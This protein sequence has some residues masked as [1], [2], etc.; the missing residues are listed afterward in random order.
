[1]TPNILLIITDQQRAD[2]IGPDTAGPDRTPAL[3][4]L[5][6]HAVT[7]SNAFTT[8]PLCGPARA[9][10][11]S[12]RYPHQA[13]GRPADDPLGVRDPGE[14]DAEDMMLNDSS[15]LEPPH[16]T[17]RLRGAGYYTGYAGKWHLGNDVIADWFPDHFGEDN[18]QYVRWLG[19]NGK[20]DGWPLHD[21]DVRSFRPP[22]MSIPRPKVN[23]I[24]PDDSNDAWIADHCVKRIEERPTDR[25]FFV[26]CGFNGPHP[27]FKIPEPY[28]S[29]F[30]PS[31]VPEPANF[32]PRPG[33]PSSRSESYYRRL[34]S[35]HGHDWSDWQKS[36][37]VYWGFVR[38]I[39]DQVGKLVDCLRREGV[40]EETVVVFCSDHGEMLG[41]HGLWHKMQ[42][43]EEAIRVPLVIAAPWIDGARR[44]D[45]LVSLIDL[46]PTILSLAGCDAPESWEETDLSGAVSAIDWMPSRSTVFVEQK[47]LGPFHGE[48]SWRLARGK[49]YK[50]VWNDGDTDELYDLEMDP[51]E[52]NNIAGR[53]DHAARL[54]E[55]RGRLAQ[56]M[57]RTADPL[58]ERYME[59]AGGLQP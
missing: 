5:R 59:Q 33:E 26:V 15:L 39:D 18:E 20:P 32:G 45:G 38:H 23:A 9:S 58:T 49:R 31:S 6:R 37:A 50:Y 40:Y 16:L 7:F 55:Y 8:C 29:M 30:D 35:D 1:M 56:W 52:S 13:R 34:W 36:V 14:A 22:H 48:V 19:V 54:A 11:F 24:D 25:P 47:P 12:G 10:L 53:A 44:N 57:R 43:Y 28:F 27:P 46:P 21:A 17:D 41:Q 51:G 2:T 4:A 3:D 42:P